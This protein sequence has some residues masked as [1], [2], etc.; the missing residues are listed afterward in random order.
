MLHRISRKDWGSSEELL[1]PPA[2]DE[3]PLASSSPHW[4]EGWVRGI[5]GVGESNK[6]SSVPSK[7]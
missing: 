6:T 2:H 5:F 4:G 7:D 1:T 3:V